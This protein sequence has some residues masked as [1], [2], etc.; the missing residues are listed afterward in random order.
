MK[1]RQTKQF[2][3]IVFSALLTGL[4]APCG[5]FAQTFT[6]F[7]C[8]EVYDTDHGNNQLHVRMAGLH[9]SI[10]ADNTGGDASS[11]T[12]TLKNVDPDFVFLSEDMPVTRGI[13][14]LTFTW[15]IGAGATETIWINP[16]YLTP[17]NFYFMAW[18]DSQHRPERFQRLLAKASLINPVLSVAS[19]DCV[20]HGDDGGCVGGG[21][22]SDVVTD[23]IFLNYLG[24]FINYPTPVFEALGNHDIVRGG[25]ADEDDSNYGAGEALW[26]KYL[27]PTEYGFT[28]HPSHPSGGVHFLINRFYYDMP[29]WC[30]RLDGGAY[31]GGCTPNGFLRFDDNDSV[32]V[33]IADFTAGDLAAAQGAAARFSVTHHG[34]NMFIPDHNTVENARALYQNGNVD[35]MIAG[36]WHR[37]ETGTDGPTGIPYLITGD[38]N[39]D[40]H[41]NNPGFSLVRVNNGAIT[42]QHMYADH[43]GLNINYTQNGPAETQ[44]RATVDYSYTS[45]PNG[46]VHDLPFLRLKF[47]LSNEHA[48]YQATDVSTGND[49]ATFS[50]R[51]NDYTVV[52]VET[53][54]N[55]GE[56]KTV[57]VD[58]VISAE[59][60]PGDS[61]AV[62]PN[63]ATGAVT[64]NL[65]GE[66]GQAYD[67]VL[68]DMYG[69]EVR[70]LRSSGKSVVIRLEGL[71]RGMYLVKVSD[72][73]TFSATKKIFVQ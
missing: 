60:S 12:V 26:R 41:N 5:M 13:N 45:D 6:C 20:Q 59:S 4:L 25:W 9:A 70:T 68:L 23:Q 8:A 39:G 43:I 38:A 40:Q 49:I 52:Y 47:R 18:G 34:F 67:V 62:F 61:I 44:G 29:N 48:A 19:G 21:N 50:H 37:Y 42:Q 24:L 30:Q 2:V 28:V 71:L 64:V 16:W 51:F 22:R 53:S 65:P 54:I 63:P 10:K 46:N 66:D 73:S 31:F 1:T 11:Y 17:D 3:K 72:G 14:T 33:A 36:H 7:Q 35:Y 15:Q 27:G 55:N 58:P 32:G 57:Q 69:N 56:T